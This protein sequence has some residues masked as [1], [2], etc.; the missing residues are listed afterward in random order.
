MHLD[1]G[2]V[3]DAVVST[4]NEATLGDRGMERTYFDNQGTTGNS[5]QTQHILMFEKLL[6]VLI[7]QTCYD[8]SLRLFIIHALHVQK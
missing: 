6:C 1:C 8:T 4:G 3:T 2:L 7:E 5:E